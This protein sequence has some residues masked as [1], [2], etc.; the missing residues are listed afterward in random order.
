M[1]PTISNFYNDD[2][3]IGDEED[4][5]IDNVG[6]EEKDEVINFEQENESEKE[7]QGTT[8]SVME[9]KKRSETDLV[10]YDTLLDGDKEGTRQSDNTTMGPRKR[11]SLMKKNVSTKRVEVAAPPREKQLVGDC[12][13][14]KRIEEAKQTTTEKQS[15]KG[16][17]KMETDWV[18]NKKLVVDTEKKIEGAQQNPTQRR[19]DNMMGSA[20]RKEYNSGLKKSM[21]LPLMK[22]NVA[23]KRVEVAP[24]N[25][26]KQLQ[27]QSNCSA[28]TRPVQKTTQSSAVARPMQKETESISD[29]KR[30]ESSKRKIEERVAEQREAKRRIIMVD[31]HHMPKPAN[32]PRAPKRCWDRRRF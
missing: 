11:M 22:M 20:A 17:K 7:K 30:F 13:A 3:I 15:H 5:I 2:M 26:H 18:Q 6:D 32:D 9:L 28:I 16:F 1:N 23:T 12:S 4:E 8:E 31:S 27:K 29:M 10:Q 24:P 14:Q 21:P 25:N 19:T